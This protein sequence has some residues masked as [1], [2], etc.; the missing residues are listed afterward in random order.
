MAGGSHHSSLWLM[1]TTF[2]YLQRDYLH[3]EASAYTS[4]EGLPLTLHGWKLIQVVAA[5]VQIKMLRS[6]HHDIFINGY[7]LIYYNKLSLHLPTINYVR[8][9]SQNYIKRQFVKKLSDLI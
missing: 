9:W 4:R 7:G 6:S 3:L 8:L 5:F 1:A 2:D